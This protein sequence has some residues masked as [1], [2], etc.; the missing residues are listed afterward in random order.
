MFR[1]AL[2]RCVCACASVSVMNVVFR[3]AEVIVMTPGWPLVYNYHPHSL[4]SGCWVGPRVRC[5]CGAI[6][7]VFNLMWSQE[8]VIKVLENAYIFGYYNHLKC[9]IY[10][11]IIIYIRE[12]CFNHFSLKNHWFKMPK[13]KKVTTSSEARQESYR[14]KISV[15]LHIIDLLFSFF[16]VHLFVDQFSLPELN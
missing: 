16:F 8:T 6:R 5:V 1:Y 11:Y 10:S 14:G 13:C 4:F 15:K 9:W 2:R 12:H 3:C 7:Q